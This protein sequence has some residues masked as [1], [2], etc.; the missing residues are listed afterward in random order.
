MILHC[1][2]IPDLKPVIG[3][4][5]KSPCGLPCQLA[6]MSCLS[7]THT[8]WTPLSWSLHHLLC[9]PSAC[10]SRYFYLA[11]LCALRYYAAA[12]RSY[13]YILLVYVQH[14]FVDE[15]ITTPRLLVGIGAHVHADHAARHDV[16]QHSANVMVR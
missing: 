14:E 12:P 3:V 6:Q 5:D 1:I 9:R 2:N 10:S 13:K 8:T 7:F 15:A 16:S 4:R 11:R